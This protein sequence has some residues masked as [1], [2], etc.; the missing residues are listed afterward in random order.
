MGCAGSRGACVDGRGKCEGRQNPAFP[1]CAAKTPAPEPEVEPG[2]LRV[3]E[4]RCLESLDSE[5]VRKQF[6]RSP[7]GTELG[8][9]IVKDNTWDFEANWND[10]VL[11]QVPGLLQLIVAVARERRSLK[12]LRYLEGINDSCDGLLPS[13]TTSASGSDIRSLTE[14]E[15][16]RPV[17]AGRQRVGSKKVRKRR[18][19]KRQLV[20]QAS[21]DH[22]R[23]TGA[24][25]GRSGG[26]GH[27][28]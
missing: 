6:F 23:V 22:E 27:R 14:P 20:Q 26:G 12:V 1:T 7:L 15:G 10:D 11:K 9:A 18:W 28:V 24:E 19:S 13:P 16:T 3:A 21:I 4:L 17:S 8:K 25:C 5:E 2:L